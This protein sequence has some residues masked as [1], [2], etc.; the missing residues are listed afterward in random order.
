MD[1][2]EYRGTVMQRKSIKGGHT[3]QKYIFNV[4]K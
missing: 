1:M 3:Q 2:N 4:V